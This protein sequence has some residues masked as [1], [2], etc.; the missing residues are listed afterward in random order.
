MNGC[1]VTRVI[2]FSLV[3]LVLC[4]PAN[5]A[6]PPGGKQVDLVDQAL[7]EYRTACREAFL[8]VERVLEVCLLVLVILFSIVIFYTALAPR[9]LPRAKPFDPAKERKIEKKQLD[10]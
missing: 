5:A 1:I 2:T 10:L 4:A 6:G 7:A 8:Q 3:C 9:R